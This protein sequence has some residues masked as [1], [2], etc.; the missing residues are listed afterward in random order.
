MSIRV[1]IN[2]F[3]N[4]GRRFFRL[5]W[6]HTDIEVVAVN[7][8]ADVS[9][10][11]HLLKRDSTY[12]T[13]A[14]PVRAGEDH[15][16]V[17][18]KRIPFFARR[19][20]GTI[21]WGDV[22]ADI[23]V[24][25]TAIFRD[26]RDARA[27][28]DAGASRVVISAPAKNADVTLVPGINDGHYIADQHHIVSMASC[29]T[30]CLAPMALTLDDEFGLKKG[31]MTT[32][33]AYTSDQRILDLPHGDWRRA[34]AAATNIIPTSTGAAEAVGKVLPHLNGRLSGI[35][36]RVP[37]PTVSVVDLVA[38]LGRKVTAE[39]VNAAFTE[40]AQG[41][42]S[43]IMAATEEPLVSSDL[44]GDP[45][46]ATV[47]LGL[48]MVLKDDLVKVVA[49]YDNEWGYSA[50]LCDCILLLAGRSA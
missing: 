2:G 23:I 40:R 20:P 21:P 22:G 10:L 4:I 26:A 38:E 18:G 13:F 17:A 43:G 50:R 44:R 27:H 8:I 41:D 46:S 39:Q 6:D 34:R 31:L 42:L 5:A 14:H 9:V 12:G 48:T 35:S 15:V 11:A 25:S 37:V 36:M 28:I 19:D 16:E 33:H 29:T 30:N 45:H 7:D 3:G 1:G 32:V 24:E 49:W 47:D